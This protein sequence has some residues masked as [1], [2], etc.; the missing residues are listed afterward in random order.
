MHYSAAIQ[1]PEAAG[2]K[3]QMR[4]NC[5]QCQTADRLIALKTRPLLAHDPLGV[6]YTARIGRELIGLDGQNYRA[7]CG[8]ELTSLPLLHQ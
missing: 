7:S 3:W 1:I 2:R 5:G 8:G 4:V 6:G